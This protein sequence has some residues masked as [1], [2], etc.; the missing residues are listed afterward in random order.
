MRWGTH[1][2]SIYMQWALTECALLRRRGS[3]HVLDA[4]E[5]SV[6]ARNVQ[7]AIA[8]QSAGPMSTLLRLFF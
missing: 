2:S 7:N 8:R 4:K 3:K 1:V 6:D 5:T